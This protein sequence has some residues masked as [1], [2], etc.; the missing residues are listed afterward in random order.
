MIRVIVLCF[1]VLLSISVG[2]ADDDGSAQDAVNTATENLN[3]LK[4][5]DKFDGS[6]SGK[7]LATE[8]RGRIDE[9]LQSDD[10]LSKDP[11]TQ[12]IPGF[13]GTDKDDVEVI[14][15]G[16]YDLLDVRDNP[17]DDGGSW[18][19]RNSG[20]WDEPAKTTE[21]ALE[22]QND[23]LSVKGIDTLLSHSYEDCEPVELDA[24]SSVEKICDGWL[25]GSN[26]TCTAKRK[27]TV[28]ANDNF[29]CERDNPKQRFFCT[30]TLTK[31]CARTADADDVAEVIENEMYLNLEGLHNDDGTFGLQKST[32]DLLAEF[33]WDSPRHGIPINSGVDFDIPNLDVLKE[34]SLETVAFTGLVQ[35]YVNGQS[36]YVGPGGN[37]NGGDVFY[38]SVFTGERSCVDEGRSGCRRYVYGS[39]SS[40]FQAPAGV[41]PSSVSIGWNRSRC[42]REN[43][44]GS[45]VERSGGGFVY[46]VGDAN[47]SCE[48]EGP[49]GCR[50]WN[51]ENDREGVRTLGTATDFYDP[52][53][54]V[55]DILPYL[56]EGNNKIAVKTFGV[57]M[58][59]FTAIFSTNWVKCVDF[60][61][62]WSEVCE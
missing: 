22:W 49:S 59:D 16:H 14:G 50:R 19:V 52:L 8:Q 34:F 11:D 33:L 7:A 30:R 13:G 42:V 25:A 20:D 15:S 45:C 31:T 58:L 37:D 17:L 43:A 32:V 40:Y 44:G 55:I 62:V 6:A 1:G 60:T 47:R 4:D 21:K 46:G 53:N 5:G 56:Q 12:R 28:H 38:R 18:S 36:V 39:R 54:P 41:D 9:I 35:I 26:E 23:P 29:V 57:G 10:L 24:V 3:N 61:E 2:F 51:N 27:V 48:D